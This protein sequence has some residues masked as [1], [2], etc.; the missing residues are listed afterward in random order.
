MG[1][2]PFLIMATGLRTA[3]RLRAAN[4]AQC[5]EE[6]SPISTGRPIELP[7]ANIAGKKFYRGH[8]CSPATAR[9]K[10]VGL[11]SDGMIND[12]I[13]DMIMN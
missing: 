5:K 4:C 13:R 9:A 6:V 1:I 12:D 10:R 7:P 2:P 3:Q 8:G 11:F